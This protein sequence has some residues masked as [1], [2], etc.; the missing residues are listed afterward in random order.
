MEN[1]ELKPVFLETDKCN[2]CVACMKRCPTEAIRVRGGKA[3]VMYERCV[4]CGEC[5][6]VCPFHAKKEY[7]DP[8]ESIKDYKYKVIIPSPSLYGQ[9]NNLYDVNIVLTALKN[10]G[11]DDVFEVAYGAEIVSAA[12]KKHLL[13]ANAVKPMISSSCPAVTNLILMRYEHLIPHLSPMKQPEVIAA[14]IALNNA[15]EATKLDRR[16]IGVFVI[17]QCAA[18]VQELKKGK[19]A[20]YIDKVLSA[21]EIYFPLLAEMNKV[22]QVLPLLKSGKLGISWGCTT[23]EAQGLGTDNYLSVDGFENIIEVLNEIEHDKLNKIDFIEL[24]ACP[25]GCVGGSLNI[26]NPFL[27]RTRLRLLRKNIPFRDVKINSASEYM[28]SEPYEPLNIFKLDDDRG[29]AIKKTIQMK[30]IYDAL[31]KLDCGSCGAPSCRAFAEDVVKGMKVK[32]TH[33]K[34]EPDETQ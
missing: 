30:A 34:E 26:E 22:T 28:R 29:K 33:K 25:S 10:M 14:K 6:K 11:F 32:C 9:F 1:R 3:A 2:G 18:Q 31:P 27:A 24:N 19:A 13:S 16:D 4:G 7:Y 17:T 12:T 20:K 5:V 21:K 15:L 23:G 8:L